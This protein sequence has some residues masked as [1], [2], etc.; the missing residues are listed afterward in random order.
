MAKPLHDVW[1]TKFFLTSQL[2]RRDT[3]ACSLDGSTYA[4]IAGG[5]ASMQFR[6]AWLFMWSAQWLP[7]R[8][9]T[10]QFAPIGSSQQFCTQHGAT[11]KLGRIAK[12]SAMLTWDHD[13]LHQSPCGTQGNTPDGPQL[14]RKRAETPAAPCI[15]HTLYMFRAHPRRH[16]STY[17]L[18][19]CCVPHVPARAHPNNGH[20]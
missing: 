8:H 6:L 5:H 9:P 19:S 11:R 17:A 13:G 10:K 15:M 18:N 14:D 12:T 2:H 1:D 20:S 3:T 4:I 16:I 7:A